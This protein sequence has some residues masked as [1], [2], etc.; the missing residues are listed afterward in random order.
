M[1]YVLDH[2]VNRQAAVVGHFSYFYYISNALKNQG[3]ICA[4]ARP[5]M[6]FVSLHNL[7]M[8]ILCNNYK[9]FGVLTTEKLNNFN[10]K[11]GKDSN[12]PLPYKNNSYF[13]DYFPI[14]LTIIR[15]PFTAR[16]GCLQKPLPKR[17]NARYTGVRYAPLPKRTLPCARRA[18]E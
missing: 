4:K 18:K 14:L 3:K 10:D 5:F 17:R 16:E 13:F 1:P 7:K 6:H 11:M 15:M 12:K 2:K 9:L 8:I